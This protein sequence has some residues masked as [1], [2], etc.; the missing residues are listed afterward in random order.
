MVKQAEARGAKAATDPVAPARPSAAKGSRQASASRAYDSIKT[1]I[2][3]GARAAGSHIAEIEVAQAVG[4]S[5]TPV[6]E[7][8]R[9]LESE[10]LVQVLPNVGAF[11]S[12]WSDD[13]IN[14]LFLLR[15]VIEAFTTER[16]AARATPQ[17]VERL[18][19]LADQMHQVVRAKRG[20]WIRLS[21]DINS[22][23]HAALLDIAGS[24]RLQSIFA[25]VVEVPLF[26][27]AY[28]R[29]KYEEIL[30]SA[31]EHVTI[32]HAIERRDAPWASMLMRAHL[33]ATSWAYDRNR[34]LPM[35]AAAR[36]ADGQ[37]GPAPPQRLRRARSRRT[38]R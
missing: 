31:E 33:R 27:Q 26:F 36:T 35:M 29:A 7:A 11:V 17:D 9:R 18:R 25:Q 1:A 21:F 15:E 24:A 32:V 5:R 13:E 28:G 23:F 4:I 16:A 10:G 12:T 22:R 19:A 8:L 14:E 38:V 2:L 20:D 6:R 34:G 37:A 30:R 3:S